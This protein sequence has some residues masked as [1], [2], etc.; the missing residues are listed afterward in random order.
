[1][2]A[3]VWVIA[4][5]GVLLLGFRVSDSSALPDGPAHASSASTQACHGKAGRLRSG[6]V[7]FSFSCGESEDVTGFVVRANRTLHSV[8]DPSYAFGCQRST[9]RSFDCEDIH[10]GA[11]PE[12]SGVA[13]VSEPLCH[14]HAHLVLWVTP[15]LNFEAQSLPTFT[16]KGPC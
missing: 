10:S 4:L 15:T 13:S 16:L 9:T 7:G 6:H 3:R 2:I 8:Y 1:M 14:A 5:L 12:G 11:G